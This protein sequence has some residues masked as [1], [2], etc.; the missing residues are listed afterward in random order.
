M[1]TLFFFDIRPFRFIS[2][3][4]IE[5]AELRDYSW[6]R[7]PVRDQVDIL[8][9]QRCHCALRFFRLRGETF[10]QGDPMLNESRKH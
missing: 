9:E 1:S 5:R 6:K 7:I 4:H 10:A 8:K 3:I 2:A